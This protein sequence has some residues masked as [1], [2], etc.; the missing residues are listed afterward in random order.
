MK[1][2]KAF[3]KAFKTLRLEKELT[4]ED[5][6]EFSG[7]T[8]ISELERMIK[9]PTIEKIDE[10]CKIFEV[11]PLSL[12]ALTYKYAEPKTSLDDLLKTI[13]SEIEHLL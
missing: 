12:L 4:Q 9:T 7:R 6:Y 3:A 1:K 8:Y 5:F 2:R 10:L 11:H 13:K